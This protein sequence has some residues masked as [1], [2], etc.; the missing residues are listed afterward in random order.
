MEIAIILSI[1]LLIVST[2]V[3]VYICIRRR[4]AAIVAAARLQE[5]Q[6]IADCVLKLKNVTNHLICYTFFYAVRS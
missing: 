2:A 6:R 3:L 1:A 5:Q 4:R